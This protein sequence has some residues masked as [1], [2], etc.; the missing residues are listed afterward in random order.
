MI[1]EK[2]EVANP[3]PEFFWERDEN[4][5]MVRENNPEWLKFK[6]STIPKM[7]EFERRKNL[8]GRETYT[9]L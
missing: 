1:N 6:L 4:G 9:D 8:F 3:H 5:F 7:T 2:V